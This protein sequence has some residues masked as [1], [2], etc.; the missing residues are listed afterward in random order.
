MNKPPVCPCCDSQDVDEK[1]RECRACHV[2]LPT[3]SFDV[4][5]PARRFN[6]ANG[7]QGA[8]RLERRQRAI[9]RRLGE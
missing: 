1:A 6:A 7:A 4:Y 3:G 5:V 8:Q 2:G 9:D